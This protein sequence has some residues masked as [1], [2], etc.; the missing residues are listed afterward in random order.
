MISP[1]KIVKITG[2]IVLEL[3]LVAVVVG[4]LWAMTL[5]GRTMPLVMNP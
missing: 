4:L 3:M 1:L 2:L 5:P